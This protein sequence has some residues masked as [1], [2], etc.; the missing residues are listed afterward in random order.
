MLSGLSQP[1][2]ILAGY[3]EGA[4]DYV[5]KPVDLGVLGAKVE[6]LLLRSRQLPEQV[7]AGGVVLVLHAKGGSGA[8]TVA[9][10]LAS[11]AD[12]LT[13]TGACVLDLSLGFG[14]A[15]WQL[16]L[17]PRLS[18]ADLSLQPPELL[19]GA[20]FS[21]FIAEGES[22]PSLVR[23][24]GRP[25]HG[26]LVTV[27][28]VQSAISSLRERFQYVFIDCPPSLN[29]LLLAALDAC[30]L[31]CVVTGP[32]RLELA[33][34]AEL[35]RLLTRLE[36]P[37]EK[38]L[39]ILDQNRPGE[40]PVDGAEILDRRVDLVVPYSERIAAGV[41]AGKPLGVSEGEAPELATLGELAAGLGDRLLRSAGAKSARQAG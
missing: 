15:A 13:L 30:D 4:D 2:E 18:L 35:L 20:M 9:V 19:D 33:L 40:P 22:G 41:D 34:T 17:N 28:A 37:A 6:A 21:K 39:L 7:E 5:L 12:R 38:Q 3:A 1:P 16:G 29:E 8:T 26:E 24:T 27:P 36:V 25:E 32:T 10:N 23:A 11:M 14:G 31:A